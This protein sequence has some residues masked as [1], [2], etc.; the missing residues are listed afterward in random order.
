MRT[1]RMHVLRMGFVAVLLCGGAVAAGW[2]AL[3]DEAGNAASDAQRLELLATARADTACPKPVREDLATLIGFVRKWTEG[4]RLE[5]FGSEVRRND[6]WDF[7]IDA[8]SPVYPQIFLYQG[9][10]LVWAILEY[11]GYGGRA[12]YNKARE[13][14]ERAADAFPENPIPPMY[15]GE[16]QPAAKQYEGV[17][18]APAWAVR[19]RAAL[20]HLADIIQWWAAHRQREDGQYGGGWGDDCEMWRWWVP[21]LLGFED[22]CINA[23]QKRL[24]KGLMSQPH[25]E[26][27]YTSH[28]Y[29]VEHTAEDSADVLTPM[30][31]LEPENPEWQRS[32]ERLVDLFESLWTGEN[33]RGF[34]Q[35][36]S[37][38]FS[39]DQ[40]DLDAARACDTVYHPRAVQPAL[41][42]WQRTGDP[43]M[44]G[45]FTRWMDTWVDAAA[46]AERGK[47][48]GILPT[49]IHWPDGRVGGVGEDWWDP[50]NH[51][52]SGL[53][54]FPSAMPLMTHTLL[55]AYHMSGKDKYLAP[56]RSMAAARLRYLEDQ[57]E[58]P[59]PGSA[60]WCAVKMGDLSSVLGKYRFLTGSREFDTLLERDPS[61]YLA[62]RLH[63]DME[64]LEAAL[65]ATHRAL[66]VNFEGY[67]SEVRFTDRVLRFPSLFEK[68]RLFEDG[69]PG[70]L[71]PDTSLLY[72]SVT[73]DP[74]TAGYLP[75]CAVRWKTP[76]RDLAA[77]VTKSGP[78]E[79]EAR[80]FHFGEDA[81][82]M[83]A[84]FFL[85]EPGDYEVGV[86]AGAGDGQV[87]LST[88]RLTSRGQNTTAQLTLPPRRLCTV[89][90]R[91]LDAS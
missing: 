77:L 56:I 34:L 48:A 32:A 3:L 10:M 42:V 53:Y 57:P 7:G 11:G 61:P 60:M 30:M 78:K 79:F 31:H 13:W 58:D 86:F 19:Q 33:E 37:T 87:V 17:P 38:Y 25:M 75:L 72:S 54:R 70:F 67:T 14:F 24:S 69:K 27:G 46:R 89:Q 84:Q 71:S 26:G 45:L 41:L 22:E 76:P 88:A 4:A 21:L 29:D 74:G 68:G 51:G 39:V 64:T 62:F 50:R 1:N 81:R 83:Q 90:A 82:E 43:R 63:G 20:E 18:G 5:F 9:R 2:E 23:A 66:S 47:P 80:L 85:L 35:F 55:L 6:G 52:E 16:P 44:A 49:A 12:Q 40:V 15:L 8:D 91:C 59:E 36:K 73:G 28:V 65:E